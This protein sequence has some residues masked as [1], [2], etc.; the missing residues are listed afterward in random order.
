[1]SSLNQK[2]LV[3]GCGLSYSKQEKKVWTNILRVSGADILDVSGPAVTN[4][5]ILDRAYLALL[6]NP[7]IKIVVLQLTSQGKLDVEVDQERTEELVNCDSLRNFTIDG[8]W[9]S[10]HSL[11]HPAKQL[12][13]KWLYS[14]NLETQELF[15]KIMLLDHWCNSHNISLSIIQGYN[16]QWT[17]EQSTYLKNV[18]HN[19]SSSIYS[20][21]TNSIYYAQHDHSK[22]NT[23]PCLEYQFQL[24]LELAPIVAPDTIDKVKLVYQQH[25][26]LF[27]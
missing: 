23:I 13:N 16:I 6:S 21:Y 9:P 3:S 26:K 25:K 4:Q 18:I 20:Q 7:D 17:E 24:A 14:P 12:W 2:I 11:E 5:W 10:S 15:C 1:M 19:L 8:V 22:Q 27:T